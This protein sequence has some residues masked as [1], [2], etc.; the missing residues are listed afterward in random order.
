MQSAVARV[1]D[2]VG[3]EDDEV[4]DKGMVDKDIEGGETGGD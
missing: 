2:V 3:D 4:G 1:D